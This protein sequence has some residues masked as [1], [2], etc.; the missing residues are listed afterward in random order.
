MRKYLIVPIIVSVQLS[1]VI[2]LQEKIDE[3][4]QLI[5]NADPTSDVDAPELQTLEGHFPL[6]VSCLI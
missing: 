3:A 5:Q 4:L 2:M 1:P 6:A